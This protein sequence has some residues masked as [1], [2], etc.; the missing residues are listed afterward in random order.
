MKE[1]IRIINGRRYNTATATK[2]ASWDNGM[3]YSDFRHIDEDLYRTPKGVFFIVGEGGAL[4]K[5]AQSCGNNSTCGGVEW[6]VLSEEQAQAWLEDHDET[7]ALE[8]YFA[9]KIQDA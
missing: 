1:T 9:D 5:Y 3:G 7:E 2:I 4:S 6:E 8:K